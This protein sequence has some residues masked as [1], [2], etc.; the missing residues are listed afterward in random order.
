MAEG[1]GTY[2]DIVALEKAGANIMSFK[3]GE[4]GWGATAED[5]NEAT[6][7]LVRYNAVQ[8]ENIANQK[9]KRLRAANEYNL[10]KASGVGSITYFNET[11]GKHEQMF[12]VDDA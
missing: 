3:F 6:K 9:E 12:N 7:S 5:I 10:N 11:S 4:D 8:M 1:T 2:D